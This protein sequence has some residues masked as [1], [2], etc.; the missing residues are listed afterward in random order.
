MN[1][2]FRELASQADD[3]CDKTWHNHPNYSQAWEEKFAELI[4]LECAV[5][6]EEIAHKHQ[7][8]ETTYAAGKKAGAFEC[9]EELLTYFGV[10]R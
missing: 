2:R 4:V 9:K 1:N 3:W 8:E 10:T 6:C 7:V 5:R